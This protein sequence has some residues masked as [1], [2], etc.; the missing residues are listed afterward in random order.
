MI[1][2]KVDRWAG[3]YTKF[4]NGNKVVGGKLPAW[5]YKPLM[6]CVICMAS[7]HGFVFYW[8]MVG[9]DWQVILFII[10]LSGSNY[11]LS[12]LVHD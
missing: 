6:G 4:S 10:C 11:L 12:Q 2:E 5:L 7:I 3:G 1:L 9:L 8:L